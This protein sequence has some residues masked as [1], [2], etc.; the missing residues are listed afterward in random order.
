MIDYC[1][2]VLAAHSRRT[3]AGIRHSTLAN[4]RYIY[5]WQV[6]FFCKCENNRFRAR[7]GRE[8]P[9]YEEMKARQL[10]NPDEPWPPRQRLRPDYVPVQP[11]LPV[12]VRFREQFEQALQLI[13]DEVAK[14]ARPA[15]LL[16][17]LEERGLKTRTGRK[18]TAA[19]VSRELVK[20]RGPRRAKLDPVSP[21]PQNA[22]AGGP[23][24]E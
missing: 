5:E 16:E 1:G 9:L 7:C 23:S 13:R 10:A 3:Y 18:W 24:K 11:V 21:E 19:A 17:L 20:L 12:K 6:P 2:V 14:G 15:R 4:I 8:C 22:V